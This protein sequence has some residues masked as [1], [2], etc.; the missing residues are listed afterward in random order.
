M[1]GTSSSTTKQ[2]PPFPPASADPSETLNPPHAAGHG[3]LQQP[4][5]AH[6][7]PDPQ[8]PGVGEDTSMDMDMTQAP[9]PAN[10]SLAPPAPPAGRIPTPIQPSFMT[11]VRGNAWAETPDAELSHPNGIN[12]MGHQPAP[13]APPP[14]DHTVP[15]T[16]GADEWNAVRNR[17]LPSPISEGEDAHAQ[18]TSPGMVLDGST[19]HLAHR[20]ASQVS[21]TTPD[22]HHCD[23]MSEGPAQEAE[24]EGGRTTPSPGRKGHTRSRHTIDS[25]TWQPGMKK[26]FSMG[27]RTDCE[28]CRM[29]VPG[30][31]NHIIVS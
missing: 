13:F 15:R 24:A 10:E 22:E 12:N 6:P 9:E 18:A 16:V 21:I 20:L 4:P 17:R 8:Q 31:F 19:T 2:F 1:S 7:H 5:E 27:Y 28:K 3:Q 30:H 23:H 25:W 29:K 26:T 11:Q 14:A